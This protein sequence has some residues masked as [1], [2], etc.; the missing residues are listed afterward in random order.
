MDAVAG[1]EKE[2]NVEGKKRT[3][4]IPA[5]VDDG[6]QIR[7]KEFILY[8]DV[9]PDDRFSRDGNDVFV[10]QNISFIQAS[11][12]D[13]ISVQALNGPIK[14]KV[15]PGT[16]SHTLVRLRGQGIKDVNG[17]GQGDFYIRL[18]VTVPTRLTRQQ[19]NLLKQL[20]L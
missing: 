14:I 17:Y 12:G 19:K 1:V 8:I 11:L 4:K 16:Q 13:N 2:V 20:D 18:I 7:F 10:T 15:K 9:L 3:I 6:Q 5:G